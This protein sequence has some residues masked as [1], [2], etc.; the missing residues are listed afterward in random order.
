[1]SRRTTR[2]LRAALA[3]MHYTGVDMLAAPYTR[4]AGVI[5][6]LHRVDPVPPADF[7]PN[8][9][10]KVTP[11]FIEA[12][13]Q[14]VIEQGFDILALDEVPA[15]L[16]QGE[17]RRPFA[18]FTFDDGYRDNLDVAYPI[19][20]RYGIP[21]TVSIPTDYIDGKG[22]LWWL[23]L[24]KAIASSGPSITVAIRGQSVDYASA[25]ADEKD[26][27]F[28]E[29]YWQLRRLPEIEARAI[30]DKLTADRGISGEQLCRE[31]MLTWDELRALASDP[32]VTIGAH[33]CRHL[34]LAK[35]DEDEVRREM[36]A[37]IARLEA[38][39]GKPCRHFSYPYGC[40]QS[41]GAREFR[42]AREVGVATAV[43]TRKGM[44]EAAHADALTAMPRLSLNGDFQDIR[45][46]KV[47]LSG[48][49]F[50]LWNAFVRRTDNAA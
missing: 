50:A 25:T 15:R 34:A 45:L 23:M 9:I 18:C 32:L 16:A 46:V 43:T 19:F 39:L 5:F 17:A 41:A 40:E 6:M 31:L 35:I 38:E 8:R 14:H 42:I 11:E 3:A 1:M 37:S 49:P 30:V 22:E 4:G 44:I 48:M 27:A 36:T 12:V 28:G 24:E 26:A 13:I 21:F 47:M 2:I 20:K 10:L 29:I 7:E 33:T